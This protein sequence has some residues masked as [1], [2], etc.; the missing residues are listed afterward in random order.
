LHANQIP[1]FV[2]LTSRPLLEGAFAL[3]RIEVGPR[4]TLCHDARVMGGVA[5]EVNPE[6]PVAKPPISNSKLWVLDHGPSTLDL[7]LSEL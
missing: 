6:T 1:S 2:A 3:N 5:V 7:E 4:A